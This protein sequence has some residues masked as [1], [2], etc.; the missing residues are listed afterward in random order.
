D[1]PGLVPQPGGQ[2]GGDGRGGPRDLPRPGLG[3]GRGGARPALRPAS[4]RH[5]RLRRVPAED[6]PEDPGGRPRADRL[7]DRAA[8]ASP[9]LAAP[10]DRQTGAVARR[11]ARGLRG[12]RAS[13]GAG[14]DRNGAATAT[15]DHW[16][17]APAPVAPSPG[18]G[19][20]PRARGARRRRQAP[21]F[22]PPAARGV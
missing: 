14:P 13:T 9:P 5:A 18:A 1:P 2:P 21:P 12:A 6:H 11:R 4:G 19:A 16:S 3:A 10:R 22:T 7:N 20:A 8:G 17:A 15:R